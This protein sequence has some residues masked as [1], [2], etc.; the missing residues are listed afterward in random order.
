ML[1]FLTPLIGGYLA[2]RIIGTRRSLVI[3]GIII[4]AGHFTLALQGTRPRSTP[5]LA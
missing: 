3:G 1:V 2:D 5:A 4:S